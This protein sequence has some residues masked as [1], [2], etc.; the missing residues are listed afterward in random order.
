MNIFDKSKEVECKMSYDQL[1]LSYIEKINNNEV[2]YNFGNEG[3]AY[4]VGNDFI[5][6]EFRIKAGDFE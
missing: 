5:V 1:L 4:Y 6:K 2:D 3:F